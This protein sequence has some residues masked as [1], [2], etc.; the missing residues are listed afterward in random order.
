M[1][2]WG[3]EQCRKE[4][5]SA[6]VESTLEAAPFYRKNGFVALETFSLVLKGLVET[7]SEEIYSEVAFLFTP[8]ET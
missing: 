6:Y 5:V 2:K 1:I 7:N 4:K 3:S 8:S